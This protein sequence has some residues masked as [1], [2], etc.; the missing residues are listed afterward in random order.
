VV[1]GAIGLAR[2]HQQTL[3]PL[4]GLSI[5]A[6]AVDSDT[7][8]GESYTHVFTALEL[9]GVARLSER[10]EIGAA[11]APG[12]YAISAN[13]EQGDIGQATEGV[14]AHAHGWA[15]AVLGNITLSAGV[16]VLSGPTFWLEPVTLGVAF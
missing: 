1:G 16:R 12:F 11:Y 10:F 2:D 15:S 14:L 6:V 9:G 4:L 5:G 8:A 7:T 13:D 3:I